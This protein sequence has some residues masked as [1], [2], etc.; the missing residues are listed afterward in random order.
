MPRG[1][2][3]PAGHHSGRRTSAAGGLMP[4]C[5]GR[6]PRRNKVIFSPFPP[7]RG[8]G[9]MGAETKLKAGL[10]GGKE[11]K[12]PAGHRQRPPNRKPAGQAPHCVFHSGRANKCR[13]GSAA[14]PGTTAA[15]IASAARVQPPAGHHSGRDSQCR[16]GSA[17]GMQGGFPLP[18]KKQRLQAKKSAKKP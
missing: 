3:F 10:A 18:Q 2:S 15:G 1:F 13:A 6:S 9:G 4:G 8:G 14:P 12:P 11:G 16:A 7:G 17:A 5:R